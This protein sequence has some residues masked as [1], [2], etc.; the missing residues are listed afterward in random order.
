[1]P[2]LQE[3]KKK[4]L[5]DL[6]DFTIEYGGDSN[7]TIYS[8]LLREK[9]RGSWSTGNFHKRPAGGR[10][11]GNHMYAMP[12]IPGIHVDVKFKELKIRVYDLLEKD[13]ERLRKINAVFER[14]AIRSL[15]KYGA[16]KSSIRQFD[17]DK[18]QTYVLEVRKLIDGGFATVVKGKMPSESDMAQCEGR[19]LNDPGSNSTMKPR[20]ADEVE[21]WSKDVQRI[22]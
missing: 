3:T 15:T 12:D 13:E 9:F 2:E 7:G 10:D 8:S 16:V 6:P 19:L 11:L 14:S 22:T 1:M 5:A 18:M 4:K 21:Q 17:P 20:Y